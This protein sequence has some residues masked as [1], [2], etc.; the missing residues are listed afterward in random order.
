MLVKKNSGLTEEATKAIDP[1]PAG[2]CLNALKMLQSKF[3]ISSKGAL[4]QGEHA[5]VSLPF[6][7]QSIHCTRQRVIILL[8]FESKSLA[9]SSTWPSARPSRTAPNTTASVWSGSLDRWDSRCEWWVSLGELGVSL[10][11]THEMS[12]GSEGEE[13]GERWTRRIHVYTL[14]HVRLERLPVYKIIKL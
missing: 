14:Y 1:M 2:H 4:Y 5:S 12:I 6:Q 9:S 11:V 8:A 3:T 7:I 10:V 13:V